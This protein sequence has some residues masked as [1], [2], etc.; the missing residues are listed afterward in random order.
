M[1]G[2]YGM[3]MN[4]NYTHDSLVGQ[5]LIRLHRLWCFLWRGSPTDTRSASNMRWLHGGDRNVM[6][7]WAV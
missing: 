3:E 4:L 6:T 5:F 7:C 1:D 2:W